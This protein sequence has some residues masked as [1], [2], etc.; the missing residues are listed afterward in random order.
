MAVIDESSASLRIRH[1]RLHEG[2]RLRD[3]AVASK[4]HWGYD[5]ERLRQWAAAGD[6][7][8]DGLRD[9][10]VYVAEAGGRAV[11]WAALIPRGELVWLD[12]LWVEPQWIGK[13]VGSRLFRHAVQRAT[14]LGGKRMEWEAE[15]NAVGFYERHGG[16]Y[17]RDSEPTS[18]GRSI[19]VMGIDLP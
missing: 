9:K 5:S 11:A 1:A 18:W 12:D 16:R 2:E 8:P 13:G 4:A 14:E 15:P 10:E 7:S 19:P 3:I 17:L 6:F